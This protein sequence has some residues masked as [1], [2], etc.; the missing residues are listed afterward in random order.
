MEKKQQSTNVAFH[1]D[2]GTGVIQARVWT[3]PEDKSDYISQSLAN[4]EYASN[5]II[6]FHLFCCCSAGTYVRLIGH[7]Q[8]FNGE[9]SLVAFRVIPIT[10]FNEVTFHHLEVIQVHLANTRP[11]P[12]D[13]YLLI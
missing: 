12:V 2:D 6:S 7:L 10:D 11:A 5:P 9:K 8:S 4:L 13:G 1:I 3:E